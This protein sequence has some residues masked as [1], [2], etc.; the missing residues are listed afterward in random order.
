[1]MPT[2]S[3]LRHDLRLKVTGPR[4]HGL[5][6]CKKAAT[7]EGVLRNSLE[8]GARAEA[9]RFVVELELELIQSQMAQTPML[10]SEAVDQA[11]ESP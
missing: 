3:V 10:R 9:N 7:V 4:R 6:Q 11:V 2:R 8:L 5:A 1:M